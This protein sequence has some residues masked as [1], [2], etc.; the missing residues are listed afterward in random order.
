M[1]TR[2]ALAFALLLPACVGGGSARRGGL[3]EETVNGFPPAVEQSYRL[4]A[5]RCSRCHTLSRPLNASI[6]E[7]EH[8]EQYVARMRRHAGSG[9]SPKDAE[10]ILVFLKYYSEQKAKQL[11][12]D[13][14][15]VTQ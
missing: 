7:Y 1:T 2:I 11:E 8:W 9:I 14:A 6:T 3:P 13:G 15:E 5:V 4:F 12:E 10:E